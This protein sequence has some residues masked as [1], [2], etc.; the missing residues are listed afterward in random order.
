MRAT[1]GQLAPLKPRPGQAAKAGCLEYLQLE[2]SK[3]NS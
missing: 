3:L 2:G 1:T